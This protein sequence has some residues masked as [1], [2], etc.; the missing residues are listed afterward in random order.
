[1][2]PKQ[3]VDVLR[4]F[5]EAMPP[6]LVIDALEWA[7]KNPEDAIRIARRFRKL[8]SIGRKAFEAYIG[9][10]WSPSYAIEA[11]EQR[12]S[13]NYRTRSLLQKVLSRAKRGGYG[14]KM[15]N[16][17][18]CTI[19]GNEDHYEFTFKLS[20]GAEV[21]L[22]KGNGRNLSGILT[23][24]L[25]GEIYLNKFDVMLYKGKDYNVQSRQAE[26]ILKAI[27]ENVSPEVLAATDI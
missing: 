5:E 26:A 18:E 2:A 24:L 12:Q 9:D 23:E 21:T 3:F 16:G 25:K 14:F 27:E 10:G 19:K 8:N 11:A 22:I 1:M 15:P 4:S 17:V 7:A 20:N 13:F 6:R